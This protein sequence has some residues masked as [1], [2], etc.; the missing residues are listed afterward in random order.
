MDIAFCTID[1][2]EWYADEFWALGEKAIVTMRRNLQCTSCNGDAWFRKSSYGNKVPHFCAHHTED[3][4]YATIYEVI[5]DGD[6]GDGQPAANPDSGIVLDL[7]LDKNYEVDVQSPAPKPDI[8]AGERRLGNEFKNGGGKDY[9]AH[10]TL[11]NTLYK[12]VRSDK[13]YTSDSKVT[14]PNAPIQGLPEKANEL[15][16]NFKDVNDGYNKV[17]RVYWGFI[18]DAGFTADGRLWLNAGNRSDGLSVSINPDITEEFRKY[19]KVDKSLD[20]LEGCHALIIGDCY[21]ATTGKPIIWCG[22]LDYIVLRRYNFD[23]VS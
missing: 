1:G 2:K 14:I 23:K 17:N 16:V 10:L 4:N 15:F 18:S 12:L 7:G 8:P 19:F 3:C 21:Y 6:G 20:Q 9:P 13:L 11:K 22:S 5:D